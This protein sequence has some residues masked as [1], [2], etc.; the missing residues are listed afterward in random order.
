MAWAL[1]AG[2]SSLEVGEAPTMQK[3]KAAASGEE[4]RRQEGERGQEIIG[5]IFIH[6]A[7]S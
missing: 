3:G 6:F 7:N 4:G 1:T 2:A 5:A